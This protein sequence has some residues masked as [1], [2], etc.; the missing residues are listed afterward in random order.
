MNASAVHTQVSAS[1]SGSSAVPVLPR[2][3]SC[4]ASSSTGPNSSSTGRA[5]SFAYAL[6]SCTSASTR[7]CGMP[8]SDSSADSLSK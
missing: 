4:A 1:A 3:A 5:A 8:R 6:S 7:P 2:A